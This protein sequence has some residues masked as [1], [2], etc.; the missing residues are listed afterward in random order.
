MKARIVA[1]GVFDAS[2]RSIVSPV[3]AKVSVPIIDKRAGQVV[4]ISGETVQLMDLETY[5]I[6]WTHMPVKDEIKSKLEPGREVE[7]WKIVGRLK[8]VRVKR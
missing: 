2:K 4:S 3:S 8:I 1:V 6:F 7:Y 5:E